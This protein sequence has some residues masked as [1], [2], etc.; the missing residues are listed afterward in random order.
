MRRFGKHR[1]GAELVR[2]TAQQF[3]ALINGAA[4]HTLTDLQNNVRTIKNQVMSTENNDHHQVQF[5]QEIFKSNLLVKTVKVLKKLDFEPKKDARLMFVH[6]VPHKSGSKY[7]A[8]EC[9]AQKP[10]MLS[11]LCGL[12][13][14]HGD[15]LHSGP[16]L[17]ECLNFQTLNQIFLNSGDVY[18]LFTYTELPTF[19]LASDAFATLRLCLTK[20]KK[21]CSVF[22]E[23]NYIKFFA[24]YQQMLSSDNYVTRRQYLKLLSDILL[25]RTN[26][27]VMG[28]YITNPH[29]LK[30]MM[31]LL[32]E[33]SPTIQ[34]EA[35][36]VFKIL[37]A[38]PRK[39]DTIV[40]ILTRN[41]PKLIKLL[42]NFLPDRD[43]D[44]QF[45]Q[46]KEYL[47]EEIR[48]L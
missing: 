47:V 43:S 16:M 23:D 21:V 35:F 1:S 7:P 2:I 6:A 3:D 15:G 20:H 38:N 48:A 34:F 33:K 17:R 4:A 27:N 46:E 19:D 24:R 31:L 37:V 22:L 29:Y 40:E 30:T 13:E 18:K 42:E 39:P 11:I 9:I 8:V 28:Q 14:S 44:E 45:C 41:K 10:E 5:W 12:Y 32:K 25:D 36:H 26:F